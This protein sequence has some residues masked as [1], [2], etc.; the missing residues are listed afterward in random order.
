M[1]MSTAQMNSRL[2][3]DA[4]ASTARIRFGR[5]HHLG[6]SRTARRAADDEMT[7]VGRPLVGAVDDGGLALTD[8]LLVNVD[9]VP[10][11]MYRTSSNVP[12][13]QQK[14]RPA[15]S[16]RPDCSLNS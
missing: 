5:L 3:L 11:H 12:S 4:D 7:K 10:H 14:I 16:K 6:S 2:R 15:P 13:N 9:D 8:P 1:G